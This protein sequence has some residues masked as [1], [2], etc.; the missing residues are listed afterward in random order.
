MVYYTTAFGERRFST[1]VD[2]RE[3]AIAHDTVVGKEGS[4]AIFKHTRTDPYGFNVGYL[5]FQRLVWTEL[6]EWIPVKYNKAGFGRKDF[7]HI[8]RLNK[9]GK[10]I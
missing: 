9:Q 10:R 4:I 8:V 6:Y 2:A 3:Y 7:D 1:L 5:R